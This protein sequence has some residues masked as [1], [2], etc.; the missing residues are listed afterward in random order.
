MSLTAWEHSDPNSALLLMNTRTGK[1]IKFKEIDWK[2]GDSLIM[3][4]YD[5]II[6]YDKE[7]GKAIGFKPES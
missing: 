2:S 1:E 4:E 6:G 7:H 3:A 5:L